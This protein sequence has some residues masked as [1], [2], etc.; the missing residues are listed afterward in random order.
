MEFSS[1]IGAFFNAHSGSIL[2]SIAIVALLTLVLMLV[3]AI[4]LSAVSRPLANLKS[5]G[6]PEDIILAILRA[7]EENQR[8]IKKATSDLSDLIRHSQ[9][10]FHRS[11]LV[12]YD[13]FED[14][15]GQQ[16]YSLCM[17]DGNGSGYIIT[18]LT[19]RNST[20]SYAVR[21]KDGEASRQLSDEEAQAF[22][23]ALAGQVPLSIT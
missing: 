4:R 13:A 5:D 12:R 10:F 21:I 11:A 22:N 3:F 9:S 6:K 15:A 17:L 18:Y 8:D 19:G 14:I 23:E 16:S 20:R 1:D 7:V 2:F